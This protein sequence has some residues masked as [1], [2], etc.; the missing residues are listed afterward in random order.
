V[1]VDPALAARIA[2]LQARINAAL[3]SPAG[4]AGTSSFSPYMPGASVP[5]QDS[6]LGGGQDR[7]LDALEAI[8]DRFAQLRAT[9]DRGALQHALALVLTHHPAM[10]AFGL[11][12]PSLDE[13]SPWKTWP[14][15]RE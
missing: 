9:S 3:H 6:L 14:S 5:L 1:G 12:L 2:A 15:R 11:R 8:L 7:G 13:R 4:E 10:A